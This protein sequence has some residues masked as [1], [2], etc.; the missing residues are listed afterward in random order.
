MVLYGLHQGSP[1]CARKSA[2]VGFMSQPD[3]LHDHRCLR[4]L[5]QVAEVLGVTRSAVNL[6][7]RDGRLGATRFG[8][9][10]YVGFD[11]LER[12]LATYEPAPSAGRKLGRRGGGPDIVEAVHELLCDWGE[13]RVDELSEVVQRDPGN[14]RKYLA[15]LQKRGLARKASSATWVPTNAL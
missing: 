9:R 11:V 10:W 4:S 5:P 2:R 15:I 8:P 3:D 14:V 1:T 7:V 6:M 12:F 13:A